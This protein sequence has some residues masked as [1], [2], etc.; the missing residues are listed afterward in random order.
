MTIFLKTMISIFL[1]VKKKGL[2]TKQWLTYAKMLILAKS[3][4]IRNYII[5]LA[6][7]NNPSTHFI[8]D[9]FTLIVQAYLL[10]FFALQ[11][12]CHKNELKINTDISAAN[13]EITIMNASQYHFVP[14]GSFFQYST[15][16]WSFEF[17]SSFM[18]KSNSYP[19]KLSSNFRS[20]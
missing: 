1:S 11:G 4:K 7:A 3:K 15:A 5:K 2:F 18:S 17:D 16:G 10:I 8:M 13:T 9:P 12:Y 20:F 14:L 19:S 6:P